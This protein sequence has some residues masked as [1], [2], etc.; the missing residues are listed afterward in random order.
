MKHKPKNKIHK[1][2]LKDNQKKWLLLYKCDLTKVE[3]NIMKFNNANIYKSYLFFL[4][5]LN[6]NE[7]LNYPYSFHLMTYS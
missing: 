4:K 7:I 3:R 1:I 5:C 6:Y 2:I